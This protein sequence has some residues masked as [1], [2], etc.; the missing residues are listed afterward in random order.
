MPDG[1]P[2]RGVVVT[3]AAVIVAPRA[4]EAVARLERSE[5]TRLAHLEALAEPVPLVPVPHDFEAHFDRLGVE[6]PNAAAAVA[7]LRDE[8][9]LRA[10]AGARALSFRP[11]L[12]AGPPGVG[13]SRFARRLATA[14][15]LPCAAMSLAGASDSRELEGTARGWA[16]AQPCWALDQVA[17][18]GVANPLLV[19]DEVDKCAREGRN[20]D[21]LAA[22][23][24][25]LE[26]GTAAAHR[27]PV[28]GAPCD[29]S[30]VSW[31]LAANDAWR[32]PRPLLS[33]LRVV[34]MGPPPSEAFAAVLAAIRGDLAAE[35]GCAQ[36][37]LPALER[38]DQ[39]WLERRWRETRSPR[40]LRKM[41]E[42]LLGAAAARRPAW[43]N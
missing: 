13:K 12:L 9:R 35:L 3:P 36:E 29:L 27:D 4:R 11:L 7:R 18:L 38:A 42:R 43:L 28:L 2:R 30:A 21:P 40:V 34:E 24:P 20:G 16:T 23:L 31:V 22:L 37:L 10:A 39:A 33:R 14:L 15:G 25:F 6:F 32:L 1:L 8:A 41:V 5:R 17:A 26:P 19:V